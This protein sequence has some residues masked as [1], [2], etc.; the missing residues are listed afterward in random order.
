MSS[1]GTPKDLA[2]SPGRS[3]RFF[4]VPQNDTV[5][6]PATNRHPHAARVSWRPPPLAAAPDLTYAY[7][8]AARRPYVHAPGKAIWA[9][10]K[11]GV[12]MRRRPPTARTA[13]PIIGASPIIWLLA[14]LALNDA[15]AAPA[16]AQG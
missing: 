10:G 16:D 13:A 1:C 11:R 14:G 9:N 6:H 15:A 7:L 5:A 4:G 3:A 2:S 12:H 8:Q